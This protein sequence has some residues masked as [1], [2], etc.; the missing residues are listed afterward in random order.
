MMGEVQ[1][2]AEIIALTIPT[3]AKSAFDIGESV[4]WERK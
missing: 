4:G 2:R 3:D 1:R